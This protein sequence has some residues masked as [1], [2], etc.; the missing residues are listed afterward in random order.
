MAL[1]KWYAEDIEVDYSETV[2][3]AKGKGIE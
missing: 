2:A 1:K 3:V